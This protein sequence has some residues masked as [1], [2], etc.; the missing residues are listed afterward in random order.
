MPRKCSTSVQENTMVP[1][2]V[3]TA[4]NPAVLSFNYM[5]GAMDADLGG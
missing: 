2:K 4:L 1:S 3:N 5:A